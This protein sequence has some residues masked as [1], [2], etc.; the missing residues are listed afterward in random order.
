LAAFAIFPIVFAEGLD[1]SSGPGLVFITLPL[2]FS[3]MPLGTAAASAFFL[4]LLIAA[5]G[6]AISLLELATMPLQNTFGWSRPTA[7]IACGAFCWTLGIAT[8]LSF[9]LWSGWFPLS[10]VP[11]FARATWFDLIDHL[12]SNILLPIG[13]FGIALFVGWAV[14]KAM[15]AAELHI[16]GAPLNILYALLRYVVP[17]AIAAAS[18]AVFL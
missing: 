16:R 7:S 14:P 18:V 13:G 12:T 17:A 4:L 5:I 3:N 10:F 6:S 9:N 8:V 2:A 11:G 15:V 1:P